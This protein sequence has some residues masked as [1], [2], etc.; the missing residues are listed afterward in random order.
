MHI[1][2]ETP[3]QGDVIA[4]LEQLDAYFAALYPP[5]SN[6]L[7][8]VDSLCAPGVVFLVARDDQGRALGCGAYVDRGG[9]GEVKRMYVEPAS[10]GQGV[11]GKLLGEIARRA[12]AAGLPALMLE[13]G[14]SQPEAIG[15]YERDGFIRCAPFGD[16][17]PDPLSL[18]MVRRL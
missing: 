2:T 4:M 3:R 14:V 1:Q 7:M 17:Q 5:E 18:F 15:L 6:H 12:A 8:D 13:A 9:Y 10:R 11:G 16:Y